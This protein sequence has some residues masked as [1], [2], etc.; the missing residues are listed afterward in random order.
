MSVD[1]VDVAVTPADLA[2][3]DLVPL[4]ADVA[5]LLAGVNAPPRL[6]AHLTLVH[7]VALRLLRSLK[8]AWPQLEVD[9][10]AVAFGAATHD[11][12]KARVMAELS[13]AGSSHEGLGESLLLAAGVLPARAR[14]ARTH[15]LSPD[16]LD[17]ED[18]LVALADKAWKG[19]REKALEDRV[20]ALLA[21]ATG[22]PAW[23]VFMRLDGIVQRL[24]RD[25]DARLRWQARFPL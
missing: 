22:A 8:K 5:L 20:V 11:I 17:R 19:K 21:V 10:E 14:F 12:G 2:A 9:A 25:A 15:G 18:A 7:D 6:V 4:P 3:L 13:A 24:A 23:D 16:Q 1:A